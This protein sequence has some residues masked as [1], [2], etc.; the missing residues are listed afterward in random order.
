MF[1]KTV[2]LPKM[3]MGLIFLNLVHIFYQYLSKSMVLSLIQ[4]C[5]ERFILQMLSIS[6]GQLIVCLNFMVYSLFIAA[7]KGP[8]QGPLMSVCL[9]PCQRVTK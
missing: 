6:Y 8:A 4:S 7:T 5:L 3:R 1:I 9:C 2:N